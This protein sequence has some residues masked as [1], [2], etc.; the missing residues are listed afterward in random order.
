M[1]EEAIIIIRDILKTELNL[2]DQDIWIFNQDFKIPD[3]KGLFIT[4]STINKIPF[5]NNNRFV[6]NDTQT[7][8]D[9][10]QYI[11]TTEEIN[12]DLFSKNRDAQTRQ[13]EVLMAFDSYYSRDQQ[14][15]YQFKIAKINQPFINISEVE[16]V[17]MLNRFQLSIKVL[18]WSKKTSPVPFYDNNFDP[19]IKTDPI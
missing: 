14:E 18:T 17:G 10:N 6:E 3:T 12:I 19:E 8:I 7:G 16:G 4:L 11:L 9:Q 1:N 5:A 15:K 13:F 2:T